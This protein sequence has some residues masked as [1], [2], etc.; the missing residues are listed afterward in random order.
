MDLVSL[1]NVVLLLV[2]YYF[3]ARC[4]KTK[5]LHPVAFIAVS[6]VIGIIFRFAGV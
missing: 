6:A 1:P 4:K 2:L 5:G 3:T